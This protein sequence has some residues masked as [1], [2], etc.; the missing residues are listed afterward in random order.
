VN[1][2]AN[3]DFGKC[4]PMVCDAQHGLCRAARSCSRK[5]LEQEEPRESPMLLSIKMCVGCGSCVPAC[6][7]GAVE[8]KNG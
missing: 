8:I 2:Y 6:P 3:V 7:L 4:D 1:K 5:L